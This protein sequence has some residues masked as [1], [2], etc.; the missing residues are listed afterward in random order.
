MKEKTGQR[1]RERAR[2][3]KLTGRLRRPPTRVKTGSWPDRLTGRAGRV[4]EQI[5]GDRHRPAVP[6]GKAQARS[7]ETRDSGSIA[8]AF[9]RAR[10]R[11]ATKIRSTRRESRPAGAT[12]RAMSHHQLSP[13]AG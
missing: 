2:I 3:K 1:A 12:I 13:L 4:D 7:E 11:F 6:V 10:G 8:R 5:I 9:R